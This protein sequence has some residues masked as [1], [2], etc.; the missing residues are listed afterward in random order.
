MP[1]RELG[2]GAAIL[3]A[4]ALLISPGFLTDVIGFTLLVPAVRGVLYQR[5]TSRL[6]SGMRIHVARGPYSADDGDIIDVDEIL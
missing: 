2:D 5:I 4:G 3:V 6:G 1:G